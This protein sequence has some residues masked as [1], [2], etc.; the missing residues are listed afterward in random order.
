M[1]PQTYGR[2]VSQSATSSH[3][4]DVHFA[5]T[6]TGSHTTDLVPSHAAT[7]SHLQ[8]AYYLATAT[9]RLPTYHLAAYR[10]NM[11][12]DVVPGQH[13]QR[14]RIVHYR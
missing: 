11:Q 14:C 1:L 4:D 7:S 9:T 8:L 6:A 13:G 12:V 2:I 5:Y 3:T 10:V